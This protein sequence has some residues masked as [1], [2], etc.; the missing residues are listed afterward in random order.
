MDRRYPSAY[1]ELIE[2]NTSKVTPGIRRSIVE[3]IGISALEK[4]RKGGRN[5]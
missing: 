2:L 5:A 1:I 3:E 4:T